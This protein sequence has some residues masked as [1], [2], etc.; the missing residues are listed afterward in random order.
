MTEEKPKPVR[1]YAFWVKLATRASVS[2][3]LTLI[4]VKLW[5][6]ISTDASSMLASATDSMLDT[7]ASLFTFFSVRYALQP[8]D[9]EH[10]FGHGKAESLAALVQ[11][12]LI[13]GSAMLLLVHSAQQWYQGGT[14]AKPALGIYVSIF[15]IALTLA[16]VLLQR[17][18]I[19][20]TQSKAIAAD[21]LHFQSDLLLNSAVIVAL[22]LSAYGWYWADSVFAILIAIYLAYG[23]I[24]IGWEAF[25]GL[26]DRELPEPDKE[27][28][29]AVLKATKGIHGWHDLRTRA[30]GQMRFIQCHVELDDHLS[31]RAAHDIA[32][33][34]EQKLR[35]LFPET[36]VI[37]HMDP[38]S[39]VPA[40]PGTKSTTE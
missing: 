25:Q 9:Y 4:V 27:K 32:D 26:M 2:V 1:D 14:V 23:A 19:K 33:G 36:D 22:G 20:H 17:L 3:A 40:H 39:A 28:I 21:H 11:S 12:A 16:L 34:A 13:T 8:A 24:K 5:A 15:A 37:I 7:L 18:A 30:S 35:E 31:L 38:L 6:W 10:R 29:V